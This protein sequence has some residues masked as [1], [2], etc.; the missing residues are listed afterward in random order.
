MVHVSIL[1]F[2]LRINNSSANI[3][4]KK[5][6]VIANVIKLEV[7]NEDLV[8]TASVDINSSTN[9]FGE[10]KDLNERDV[11]VLTSVVND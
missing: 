3:K 1:K 11:N 9:V 8:E 4:F 10:R 6:D 2:P 7:V 5:G